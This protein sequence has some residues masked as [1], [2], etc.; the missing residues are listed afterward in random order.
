VVCA[1]ALTFDY[2]VRAFPLRSELPVFWVSGD[3]AYFSEN[4]ISELKFLRVYNL[5][6]VAGDSVLICCPCDLSF[7]SSFLKQVQMKFDSFVIES[8]VVM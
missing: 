7:V 4:L 5:V 2:F 8:R 1:F 3:Q 6:E